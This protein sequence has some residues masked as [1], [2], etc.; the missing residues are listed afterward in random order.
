MVPRVVGESGTN[1]LNYDHIN[2]KNLL[3]K[4]NLYQI[5]ETLDC[6]RLKQWELNKGQVKVKMNRIHCSKDDNHHVDMI[7]KVGHG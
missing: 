2:G 4:A 5:V 6:S 1:S 7:L 3:S